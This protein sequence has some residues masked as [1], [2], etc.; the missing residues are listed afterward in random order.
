[1]LE[2]IDISLQ[3]IGNITTNT[4]VSNFIVN[5]FYS[6]PTLVSQGDVAAITV[7]FILFFTGLVVINKITAVLLTLIKKIIF[8]LITG[9]AVYYFFKSFLVRTAMT[10]LTIDNIIFGVVG[11][12][13][14][15]L[16]LSLSFYWLFKSFKEDV[17]KEKAKL[18]KMSNIKTKEDIEEKKEVKNVLFS[19]LSFESLKQEKN[20]LSIII[21]IT[22]AEFG[23]FSSPTI[24]PPDPRIGLIFFSIFSIASIIFIRKIYKN[25]KLGLTHFG[26]ATLFGFILS[27][28]LGHFWGNFSIETL[29]SIQY[30]ASHSVVA[31]ITGIAVSLFMSSR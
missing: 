15:L 26:I 17:F 7:S 24:A 6:L 19:D 8:F 31:L 14:G 5:Y 4:T 13:I 12:L 28:L 3:N 2:S 25:F 22:I 11:S 18:P 20:I 30:F 23:V 27:V 29:L 21:Y 9:I 10:G 1:M 16:G